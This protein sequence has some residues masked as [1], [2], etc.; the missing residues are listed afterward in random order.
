MVLSGNIEKQH[1]GGIV[2]VGSR[3]Q[4]AVKAKYKYKKI[5]IENKTNFF[6]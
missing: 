2:R 3:I 6:T 1:I 5:D 4:I